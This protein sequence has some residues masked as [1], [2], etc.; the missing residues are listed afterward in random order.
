[1]RVLL[2]EDDELIASGVVAGLKAHGIDVDHAP[3]AARAG[4]ACAGERYDA[5]V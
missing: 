1:M 2:V 5:L 4:S 3:D